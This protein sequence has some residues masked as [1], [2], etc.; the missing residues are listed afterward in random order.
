[1]NGQVIH[2]SYTD[3]VLD[4]TVWTPVNT[5]SIAGDKYA[6]STCKILLAEHELAFRVV[7]IHFGPIIIIKNK[8]YSLLKIPC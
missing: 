8:Y 4:L 3:I 2:K 1:M 7:S 5:H 6:N